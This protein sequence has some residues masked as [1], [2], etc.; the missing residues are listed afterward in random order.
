M[1][2]EMQTIRAR[3]IMT[4]EPMCVEPWMSIRQLAHL[5]AE[6][7]IS[8]AP[9]V[10]GLGRLVGLVSKTD[11]IRQCLEGT[12]NVLPAYLFETLG[13]TG[14]EEGEVT[15]ETS[16]CVEDFMTLE[17]VTV[18]PETSLR[19]LAA[20]MSSRRIHRLVVVD[21]GDKPVGIITSLDL[22]A[23]FQAEPVSRTHETAGSS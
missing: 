19:E 21:A 2:A 8:G 14:A 4:K 6:N 7:E 16:V 5:F 20:I 13:S 17:P 23:A 1:A 10:D 3:D 18:M 11:L 12:G 15:P 22:I 9:V